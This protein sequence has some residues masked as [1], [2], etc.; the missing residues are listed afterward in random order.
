TDADSPP[1]NYQLADL[2]LE[3][4]D[5]GEAAR[6]Y[7]RTAYGYTPH[8][9]SAAAGYAAIY[10][11][12]EQLKVAAPTGKDQ[13]DL[14]KRDTVASSL[15][16]ADAFPQNEHAAAILGAAADDMYEMKDYKA[17][18]EADQRVID[19]YPGAEASIQRSAWIV[20]A[21]GSFEL[22]EYPQAE[23]AYTQVLAVTPE[24]DASRAA[25]VDNLA[26]SIYKQGELANEAQD[27]RAAADHFLRIRTAAPTS[28]IRETAEYDAGAALI[29]LQ[30]WKAAV[31]ALEAFRTTFPKNKLQ[32]E[33]TKQIAYAYRQNGQLSHAAGEYE[34]IASQSDDPALRSE[35]LL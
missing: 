9:Q 22:A 3:N 30:D 17:A 21:H 23:H 32:L 5:F 35:A 7:E 19:K 27:Y 2:L 13:Q 12:R 20:V 16:F 29:R 15:K 14:I 28:S 26:A 24:G 34:R 8:P 4:K 6:Q 31:D 25:L 33:A 18:I 1:T 10:A 11:Y